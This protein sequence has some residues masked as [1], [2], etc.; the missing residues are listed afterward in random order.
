M[1]EH[2]YQL[3]PN[4]IVTNVHP[5]GVNYECE[6]CHKGLMLFDPTQ[7]PEVE[8]ELNINMFVHKCNECGKILKLPKVY[9][10]IQWVVDDQPI[11]NE[12]YSSGKD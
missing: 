9:P 2:P 8:P 5:I 11:P 3:Q 10:S 7:P 1:I 12:Y 4:E 6:F